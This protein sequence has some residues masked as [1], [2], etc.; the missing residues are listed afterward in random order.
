MGL[1]PVIRRSTRSP[2]SLSLKTFHQSNKYV[3]RLL[4]LSHFSHFLPPLLPIVRHLVFFFILFFPTHI[5]KPL[6]ASAVSWRPPCTSLNSVDPTK[7]LVIS[8]RR[9]HPQF[10]HNEGLDSS[11]FNPCRIFTHR[12]NRLLFRSRHARIFPRPLLH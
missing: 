12:D 2:G 10:A 4:F 7:Q 3:H 1:T 5:D 6:L 11:N 9:V 8:S